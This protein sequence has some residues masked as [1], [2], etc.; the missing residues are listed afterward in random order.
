MVSLCNL[1]CPGTSSV[2]QFGLKLSE[3]PCLFFLPRARIKDLHHHAWREFYVMYFDHNHSSH[4]QV[5]P[6]LPIQLQ[7]GLCSTCAS[8]IFLSVSPV[9]GVWKTSRGSI[10]K[11][12]WLSSALVNYQQLPNYGWS[13]MPNSSL[14]AGI[15]SWTCACLVHV[16][17]T[18]VNSN[19]QLTDLFYPENT[20][21][22]IFHCHDSGF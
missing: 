18:A 22:V 2:H 20:F 16:D 15:V 10:L 21:I 4:L 3:P 8:Q 1:G 19:V 14:H 7:D 11:E 13:F 5:L 12:D 6:G 17:T 9:P